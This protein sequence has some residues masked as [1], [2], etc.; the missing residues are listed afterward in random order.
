MSRAQPDAIS[1]T[2][3]E[4]RYFDRWMIVHF[5]AGTGG[6]FSNVF[7]ELPT[8]GVLAA[9]SALLVMWEAWEYVR[10]V[11]ETPANRVIDVIVGLGGTILALTLAARWDEPTEWVAFA[12]VSAAGITGAF[13]GWIAFLKRGKAKAKV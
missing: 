6:G 7:F 2:W 10:G 5:L 13:F 8:W 4:G 1:L 3:K 11:R 9:G 12:L